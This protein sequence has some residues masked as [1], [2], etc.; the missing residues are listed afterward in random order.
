[1]YAHTLETAEQNPELREEFYDTLEG[2]ISAIPNRH[3]VI[4]AEDFNAKTGSAYADFST[5]MG[6]FGKGEANTSGTRLLE[7]CQKL[8]RYLTNTTFY[9]KLCHQPH[10]G[11]PYREF[12]THSGEKR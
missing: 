12:T 5:V 7:T 8:D 9:H 3:E 6:K 10:E 11:A 4:L 2:F 1:M